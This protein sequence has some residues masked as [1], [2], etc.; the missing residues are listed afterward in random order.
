MAIRY[1]WLSKDVARVSLRASLATLASAPHALANVFF[2]YY[3]YMLKDLFAPNSN[4]L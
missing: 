4:I 2:F 1:F 3:L